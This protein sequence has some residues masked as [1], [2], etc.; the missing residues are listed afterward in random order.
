MS[1]LALAFGHEA[2]LSAANAAD[3]P[4]VKVGF[5]V[6]FAV[7]FPAVTGIMAGVNMSG[8]L[9]DPSRSIPWG[10]FAAVGVGYLIYMTLPVLL[11][12]RA[13]TEALIEDPLIMTRMAVWG[14][15][16]LV[17][18]WGATLSSAL[19][20]VLGAP[21]V[22]Q[23][24]ARDGV[25]PRPLAWLGK[26]SGDEDTPRLGTAL[27][28]GLALAAVWFGD[29]NLIAPV[30]S[31]FFLAT[32]GVLN[33]SAFVERLLNSPSYRP[34]F[35]V[36]WAFSLL[37]FLGCLAV[38][39]LINA[40]AT[41]V[42]FACIF[43]V[44]LWLERRSLE[45]AWGDV[46]RGLWMALTRAGLMRIG[47]EVD[48]KNWR[49][50]LLVLSGAPQN[51]WPLVQLA[52]AITHNRSI[53]TVSTVLTASGVT[54][55]RILKM[56]RQIR[57]YLAE[58]AVQSLV[59]VIAAPDPFQGA[60]RLVDSYG[61]GAIV[62]N[63]ILLGDTQDPK[64]QKRYGE[65]I[66]HFYANHR[67]VLIVRDS[68]ERGFGRRQRIDVWWGGLRG[69]GGLMLILSYLLSTSLDWRNS[70]VRI[71]MVAPNETVAEEMRAA[72]SERLRE[73][74]TGARARRHP[75]RGP[76]L[77]PDH[78]RDLGRRRPRAP[79]ARV[80]RG[81]PPRR[82]LAASRTTTPRSAP[83]RTACRRRC[84]SSRRRTSPSGRCW[85][86]ARG[87]KRLWRRTRHRNAR[88]RRSLWRGRT[89]GAHTHLRPEER[90]D[91]QPE[92]VRG[93]DEEHVLDR[94][95][96]DLAQLARHV[97]AVEG[98][99]LRCAAA[100]RRRRACCPAATPSAARR[101]RGASG[102]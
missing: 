3:G 58:R 24:L 63:T 29:L 17:G 20:S 92:P 49:P 21:R 65:T 61:L 69:N 43:G 47:E 34:T 97:E 53:L 68:G 95:A 85:R 100:A 71:K 102:S 38:M 101:C 64:R 6:V 41:V 8:D 30:L 81:G 9:K 59:R 13:P 82:P 86:S 79:R 88:G 84:S 19:G 1:L 37:G 36:H 96:E 46:R 45:T 25:L 54:P 39:F 31:M 56:E 83:G 51:R 90:L 93:L 67:N 74:R 5:W 70:E 62:P 91:L 10:T 15:S 66:A 44:Y 33:V 77:R 27:T 57:D 7:F 14:D 32:Y 60:E 55:G 23:A 98:R 28:L 12:F 35:R 4:A 75:R 99:G 22:L 94:R 76:P 89:G 26:G 42:A 11:Y 48:T 2:T 80:A 16:I 40:I 87:P 72:V 52:S 78:A 50:N 18:V 73:T